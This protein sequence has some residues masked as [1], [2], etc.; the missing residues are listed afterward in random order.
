MFRKSKIGD[1]KLDSSLNMNLLD[2]ESQVIY[3]S[4]QIKPYL[5]KRQI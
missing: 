3:L 1:N 4:L 2:L 5:L